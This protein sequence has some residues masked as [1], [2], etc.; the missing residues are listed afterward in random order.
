MSCR[1]TGGIRV[2][3]VEQRNVGIHMYSKACR[4]LGLTVSAY[5]R[6]T[7]TQGDCATAS[8]P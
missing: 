1:V 6:V 5:N 2:M 8:S 7:V 3:R 4:N